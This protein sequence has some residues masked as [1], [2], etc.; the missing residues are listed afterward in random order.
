MAFRPP[1]SSRVRQSTRHARPILSPTLAGIRE[2]H[3]ELHLFV[4][5]ED[6]LHQRTGNAFRQIHENSRRLQGGTGGG[7]LDSQEH[8]QKKTS[9]AARFSA[10][11]QVSAAG[12]RASLARDERGADGWSFQAAPADIKKMASVDSGA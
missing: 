1:K 4:R 10:W 5:P 9:A 3:A 8:H 12:S 7:T 2:I 6:A 11:T